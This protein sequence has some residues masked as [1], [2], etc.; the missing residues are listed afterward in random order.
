MTA[1]RLAAVLLF[2]SPVAA[3]PVPA[4]KTAD[5]PV[6]KNAAL[7]LQQRKVQKELKLTGDQRIAIVDGIA[8]IDEAIEKKREKLL[9]VPNPTADLF[10][11]L[12]EERQ[13][14]AEKFLA[15]SAKKLLSVESRNRLK[16][17]DRHVRGLESFADPD[18]Q[19][20]LALTDDQKK[21][22][23]KAVKDQ[24]EKIEAYLMQLGNDDSD[25][26][27]EALLKVRNDEMKA[28]VAGFT[29]EQRTLWT[30]LLGEPVKGFD[31]L[32]L[33]FT[34]IESED[35]VPIPQ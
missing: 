11:K 14:Q 9:R 24:E 34:L 8:D 23:E 32:E 15:A 1:L 26:A 30:S 4:T 22:V 2:I 19:K 18:V 17:I 16:Q 29:A 5:E 27:K 13:K 7:L 35:S 28:L 25:N 20:V 10:D 21:A 12:E 31:P 3:A 33:W 6:S